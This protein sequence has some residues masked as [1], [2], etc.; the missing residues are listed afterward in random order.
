MN[1]ED[2]LIKTLETFGF[3]VRRQGSLLENEKYPDNF[4]TFWNNDSYSERYYDNTD[5]TICSAFNVNFYSTNPE[6]VYS[7]MRQAIKRLKSAGFIIS[8]DGYDI[9]S[10]EQTHDGRGVSCLYVVKTTD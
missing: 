3:P 10:G 5:H 6:A 7:I 9:S 8:G 2:I 4:F 1:A